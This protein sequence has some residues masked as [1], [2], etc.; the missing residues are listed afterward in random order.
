MKKIL[1]SL[2]CSFVLPIA[3]SFATPPPRM[4]PVTSIT[5]TYDLDKFFLHIEAVHPSSNWEID[6]VRMMTVSL[7]GQIVSTTNYYH[8]TTA[9]GFSEDVQ[10]NAKAGDVITV[11]LF[12]TQGSS[13]SKDLMVTKPEAT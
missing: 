12:C 9:G 6:Y 1:L 11:E 13:M 2:F 3:V 10:L 7:N 5:L 4:S 8:Q